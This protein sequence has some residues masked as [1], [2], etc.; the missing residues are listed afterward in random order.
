[1][2]IPTCAFILLEKNSHPYVYSH[3]QYYSALKSSS[4]LL[5]MMI[6]DMNISVTNI[7]YSFWYGN[8]DTQYKQYIWISISDL[9]SVCPFAY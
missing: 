2:K 6:N 1:M 3:L 8:M 5:D 4:L 7:S 9:T